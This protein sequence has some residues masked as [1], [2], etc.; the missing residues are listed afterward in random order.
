LGNVFEISDEDVNSIYTEVYS[1]HPQQMASFPSDEELE[2]IGEEVNEN[3]L[4]QKTWRSVL[5]SVIKE[6]IGER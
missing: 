6:V 2:I 4:L 3:E 1:D 5:K